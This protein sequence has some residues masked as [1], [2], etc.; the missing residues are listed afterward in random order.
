MRLKPSLLARGPKS[1]TK[2]DETLRNMEIWPPLRGNAGFRCQFSGMAPQILGS[3][4]PFIPDYKKGCWIVDRL[5]LF[6]ACDS[7]S[8]LKVNLKVT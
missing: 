7:D 2:Y 3:M 4:G 5:S 8:D 6:S 1:L